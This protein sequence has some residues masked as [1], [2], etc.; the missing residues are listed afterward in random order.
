MQYHLVDEKNI[1][2]ATLYF[3]TPICLF[4]GDRVILGGDHYFRFNHPVEASKPG[5]KSTG[6]KMV[7]DFEFARKELSD[8][9][10]AKWV[11]LV[12]C[13]QKQLCT[14]IQLFRS[15]IEFSPRES[16]ICHSWDQCKSV[17][18]RITVFFYRGWDFLMVTDAKIATASQRWLPVDH[19]IESWSGWNL[20][21]VIANIYIS[22]GHGKMRFHFVCLIVFLSKLP[23]MERQ[24][25]FGTLTE[26][27]KQTWAKVKDQ[28][29]ALALFYFKSI[30]HKRKVSLF[31]FVI[32]ITLWQRISWPQFSAQM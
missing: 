18:K 12:Y 29:F 9:Q 3:L 8:V 25:L 10:N 23:G 4:Q 1:V 16:K 19:I 6:S 13:L 14:G 20:M 11:K 32:L 28:F 30:Q 22:R 21:L 24:T 15:E 2:S 7:K 26:R 5:R 27:K 31:R 17:E